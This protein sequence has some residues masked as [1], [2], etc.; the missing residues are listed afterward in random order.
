MGK[1]NNVFSHCGRS[2]PARTP[3]A[4]E[5]RLV[6]VPLNVGYEENSRKNLLRLSLSES[7]PTRKYRLQRSNSIHLRHLRAQEGHFEPH[8]TVGRLID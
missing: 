8:S 5:A 3:H 1:R 4:V 2:A 6:V 7:D